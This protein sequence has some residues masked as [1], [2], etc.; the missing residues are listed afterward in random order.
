MKK[1]LSVLLACTLLLGC[2]FVFASC[3]K[4]LSGAY[5]Y[6]PETGIGDFIQGVTGSGTTYTFEGSKVT[7]TYEIAGFEKNV[8]GT[9]E[10]TEND[11]EE[12]VIIF[13]FAE[14]EE[15]ADDYKGEF[16]FSEGEEDGVK[17]IKI[18]GTKY[19]K[20]EKK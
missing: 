9:Y 11:E 15:D 19:T 7:I 2:V 8:E 5:E 14:D 3:G 12:T 13:T 18:G 16:S 4:K 1:I 6:V 10:I 17:Y 20:V